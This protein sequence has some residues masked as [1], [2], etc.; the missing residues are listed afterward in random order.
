MVLIQG[1]ATLGSQTTEL[2]VPF[3]FGVA[4]EDGAEAY[5]FPSYINGSY[6]DLPLISDES[7]DNP[8]YFQPGASYYF[9]NYSFSSSISI[10]GNVVDEAGNAVDGAKVSVTPENVANAIVPDPVMTVNGT[11]AFEDVDQ[12]ILPATVNVEKDG[13]SFIPV[14]IT[15]NDVVDGKIVLSNLV[16]NKSTEVA[17]TMDINF[18]FVIALIG[19]ALCGIIVAV[20][21][22]SKAKN[23]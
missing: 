17:Q 3:Y 21:S 12:S 2:Y 14:R 6:V 22:R 15:E 4:K 20:A 18:Y 23:I 5:D 9:T 19:I 13:Y 10:S 16:L 7:A 1:T 8:I 11:F